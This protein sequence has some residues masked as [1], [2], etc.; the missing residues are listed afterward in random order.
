MSKVIEVTVVLKF[1]TTEEQARVT[2]NGVPTSLIMESLNNLSRGL[3]ENLVKEA[4]EEVPE[5]G[6]ESYLDGRLKADR[7][8]LR[9]MLLSKK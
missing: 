7:V 4:V 1:G 6:F 5:E 8:I 3:A 9:D 2:T